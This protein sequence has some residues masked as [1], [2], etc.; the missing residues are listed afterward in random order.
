MVRF[1]A[2]SQSGK[3]IVHSCLISIET[4]LRH[5]SDHF[6]GTLKDIFGFSKLN[7]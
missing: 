7:Q 3:K 5:P 6:R 4:P 1:I 2:R